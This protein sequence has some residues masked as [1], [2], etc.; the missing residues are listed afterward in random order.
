MQISFSLQFA[1]CKVYIL[2]LA[3]CKSLIASFTV[4]FIEM[5]MFSKYKKK[6]LHETFYAFPSCAYP[7]L[8]C[9]IKH[10]PFRQT[11]T[12]CWKS[13]LPVF[14]ICSV[15]C[16]ILFILKTLYRYQQIDSDRFVT[17]YNYRSPEAQL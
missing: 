13:Q 8:L 15:Q 12:D 7:F 3:C 6:R 16:C 2:V 11:E 4:W 10:S 9:S 17:Y 1:C 5:L 14:Q